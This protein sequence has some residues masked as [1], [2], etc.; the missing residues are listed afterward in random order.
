MQTLLSKE[1]IREERYFLN[2]EA[3]DSDGKIWFFIDWF[4]GL[5]PGFPQKDLVICQCWSVSFVLSLP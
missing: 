4:P 5:V 2:G 3:L 1:Y